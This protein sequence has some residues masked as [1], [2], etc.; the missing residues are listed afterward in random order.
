MR[1]FKIFLLSG[2]GE[3]IICYCPIT[4][5]PKGYNISEDPRKNLMQDLSHGNIDSIEILTD[6]ETDL[7]VCKAYNVKNFLRKYGISIT[8]FFF[9]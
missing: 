7:F 2:P 8:H 6:T 3:P 9:K 4:E 5:E 1:T